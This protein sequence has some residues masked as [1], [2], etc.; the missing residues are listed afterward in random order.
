MK[1]DNL[2]TSV[3][4]NLRCP[5]S[6]DKLQILDDDLYSTTGYKYPEGDFRVISSLTQ[7]FEWSKGQ[8][9]YEK[10]HSKTIAQSDGYYT[11]VDAETKEIYEDIKL[12][13]M[14]LDVGGGFGSVAQQARL[15]PEQIICVDPMICRWQDLPDSPY[16]Q[17][18][19]HLSK[20]V[21]IPG[22]AEDL[23]FSNTSV[24]TVHM[25]SCLDHFANPH[26]ALLEA[27]RV[28]NADGTLVI[29]L[30]L[31]GAFKL[32]QT[33][34]LR[35]KAKK[36]VKHSFVGDIYEH[37][38]DQHIFHPTEESLRTLID[39]AGFR[40]HQWIMQP[41]YFNV[42]YVVAKKYNPLIPA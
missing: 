9:H 8:L 38:F 11:D 10:Y 12:S 22:F 18:Y 30:A 32:K 5:V 2:T 39:S 35:D 24:D 6:L 23:P 20:I 3:L 34:G 26:R 42:V 33:G 15:D 14:V 41:G 4:E 16:K 25:R 13:G 40:I 1:I 37:F 36:I 7:S 28:L 19:A 27:R 21:R 17:H 29:G 31:E